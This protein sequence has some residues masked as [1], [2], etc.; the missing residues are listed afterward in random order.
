MRKTPGHLYKLLFFCFL[1]ITWLGS[2]RDKNKLFEVQGIFEG[3]SV[4]VSSPV[5]GRVDY[6]PVKEGD[7][8]GKGDLVAKID[9]L[10]IAFQRDYILK[11]QENAENSGIFSAEVATEPLTVQIEALEEERTRI[12]RLVKEEVLP[13]SKLDEV[14]SKID[15]LKAQKQAT[16]EQITKKNANSRGSSEALDAQLAQIDEMILRSTITA[17]VG[18]TVLTTYVHEGELT[19]AG[20]PILKMADLS[21]L[22]LRIYLNPEQ[23]SLIKIGD[24]V[25]V[26]NDMGGKDDRSYEGT[27]SWISEKAEFTPKNIETSSMRSTL[28]YAA[29]VRVPNDGYLKIGQYGKALLSPKGSDE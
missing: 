25:Q 29:K 14:N 19:G 18:G 20:R 12:E 16:A 3:E 23:L 1:A 4:L 2:C 22:T 10:L 28:I 6:M 15:A 9:T 21:T 5:D 24:K 7:L 26:F 17:P 13:K 27:V 8:L 11:Q